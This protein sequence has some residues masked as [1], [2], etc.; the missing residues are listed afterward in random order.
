MK[1]WSFELDI[2]S[3]AKPR[4]ESTFKVL[5]R[6]FL[7]AQTLANIYLF[8]ISFWFCFRDCGRVPMVWLLGAAAVG[9]LIRLAFVLIGFFKTWCATYVSLNQLLAI[10]W[11]YICTDVSF[12]SSVRALQR[13][14]TQ[15]RRRWSW[16]MRWSRSCK[17]SFAMQ[18]WWCHHG[19]PLY[20]CRLHH[21]DLHCE[22]IDMTWL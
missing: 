4:I 3:K 21:Q 1:I 17:T 16:R 22:V 20:Q 5:L 12:P 14:Q 6:L 2:L 9:F 11:A 15:S 18:A 10:L 7:I 13:L 19:Y 8:T